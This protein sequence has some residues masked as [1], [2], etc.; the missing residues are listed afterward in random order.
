MQQNVCDVCNTYND[1]DQVV[2]AAWQGVRL[3]VQCDGAFDLVTL[4]A[5]GTLDYDARQTL[6]GEL[7]RLEDV[8]QVKLAR[9]PAW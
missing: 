2:L 6:T 8:G 9:E 5:I 3:L 4:L 7:L 1:I